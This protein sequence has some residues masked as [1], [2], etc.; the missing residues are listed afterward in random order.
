MPI[1]SAL[2]IEQ[3]PPVKFDENVMVV[4]TNKY[5]RVNYVEALPSYTHDFGSLAAGTMTTGDTEV[6]NLYMPD[7]EIAVYKFELL[8]DDLV[9]IKEPLGKLKNVAKSVQHSFSLLSQESNPSRNQQVLCVFEDDK[10]YFYVTNPTK[11]TQP[12][13]R[14]RFSGWRLKVTELASKP[15]KFTILPTEGV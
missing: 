3:E 12:K 4:P 13:N 10:T 6:S 1:Y 15:D 7:G 8:D 5:Y 11:Y 14:I 9:Q 2:N